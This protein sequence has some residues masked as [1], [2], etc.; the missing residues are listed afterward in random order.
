MPCLRASLLM[1]LLITFLLAGCGPGEIHQVSL[2]AGATTGSTFVAA[3]E[4]EPEPNLFYFGFDRRL[5]ASEDVR[6]YVPFL[7]YLE[8]TTGYRFKLRPLNR[9]GSVVDALGAETVHF[10]AIGTL[11]YLD[12]HK[13]Y[14]VE[15]LA[16]AKTA[17]GR[18]EY[19][20]LVIVRP[21]SPIERL[22][23]LRDHSL[24]LG[25]PSSTQGNLIPRVMLQQAGI[26]MSELS[27]FQNHSSHFETANA[28]L[29]GRFDA[30]AVQDTLGRELAR[31]GLVRIVAESDPFPSS[32]I[33]VVS[34]VPDEVVEEVRRALL[35]FDP[36]ERDSEGLYN[37]EQSEMPL[38]FLPVDQDALN[39]VQR[40]AELVGLLQ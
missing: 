34:G 1:M 3:K 26:A 33:S 32:T 22:W 2:T 21:D 29:N 7:R 17:D 9:T 28:V 35:A 25:S 18:A 16:L 6:M 37:W 10:A 23:D 38:G 14:G 40:L 39:E 5:D 19:R 4:P 30:G 8:R 11:S 27:A 36:T 24:A 20:A 31:K 13:R 15:A 12:A